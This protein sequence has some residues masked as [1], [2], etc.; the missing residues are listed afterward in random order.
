MSVPTSGTTRGALYAQESD[1]AFVV[2]LP[3]FFTVVATP[4]CRSRSG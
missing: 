3:P 1:E 4:I 2:L